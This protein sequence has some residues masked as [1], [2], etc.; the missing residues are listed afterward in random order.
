L[1]TRDQTTIDYL[2]A[3]VANPFAG[4][5]PGQGINGTTIGRSSL[6]I[7]YPQFG[8]ITLANDPRGSSYFHSMAVRLEKRYSQG[9]SLL[10][11]FTYSKLMERRRFLNDSDPLPEKRI[12]PDDRPLREVVSASYDLPF[13]KGKRFDGHN[14]VVNRVI[15]GFVLNVIYNWEI[16]APLNWEGQ[17]ALFL[18]GDLQSD[19]R[20]IDHA[21]DTTRFNTVSAQQLGSNIRTFSS[22]FGNL[23]IDGT[24]NFDMSI[25]KNTAITERVN[26]QLRMEAFNALNHPIFDAPNLSPTNAAFGKITNQPNLARNIQLG[27]RLV[28]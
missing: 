11:N 2:S 12:S 14:G 6:L 26:L 24:N 9:L 13:G 7:P 27:A 16:G 25:I 4:L 1:P 8:G 21:F 18:G 5:V 23:R 10:T 22:R 15:G 19:P 3:I 20:N 28:F 17:N